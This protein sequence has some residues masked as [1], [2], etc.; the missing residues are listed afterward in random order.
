ML[1]FQYT[2]DKERA[3]MISLKWKDYFSCNITEIDGQHKKLFEIGD[4]L[5]TLASLNDQY[6]HYDE[7]IGIINELKD[8]TIYHFG[9]EEKL[10]IEY[11][12]PYYAEH[13]AQHEAFIEK[14]LKFEKE[15]LD[16]HQNESVL[17]LVAFVADW[18]SSHILKTDTLYKDFF[19]EKGI[20]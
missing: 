5:F 11:S 10:M 2:K 14:V 19:N 9:Y 20:Y 16:A 8:Y 1:K 18:I 7:I 17:Q 4:H 6:D 13:K 3:Y 12:Y 15:D